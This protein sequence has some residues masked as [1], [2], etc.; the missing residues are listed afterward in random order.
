MSKE[1]ICAREQPS[2]SCQSLR[3]VRII[4][5]QGE[6][7]GGSERTFLTYRTINQTSTY[8]WRIIK[9]RLFAGLLY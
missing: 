2:T 7:G 8:I 9:A 6:L 4:F 5:I 1:V 3:E